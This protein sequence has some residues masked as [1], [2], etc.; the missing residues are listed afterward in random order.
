MRLP[1]PG[2]PA[3]LLAALVAAACGSPEPTAERGEA[4]GKRPAAAKGAGPGAGADEAEA[5]KGAPDA[6]ARDAAAELV[7]RLAGS[8][9]VGARPISPRS[10]SVKVA[11]ASGDRAVFKPL[12]KTNRTARYEVAFHRIA[13]LVGA[14]RVPASALRRVPLAQIAGLLEVSYP[15]SAKAL[16]EEAL[17]DGNGLVGGA[18]IEWI[19]ELGPP[20]FA[21]ETGRKALAALLAADGPAPAAEPGV[22]AAS[23]MVVADYV[24]GNWDRFSG[25]N[26]F[27]DA[28]GRGL[29]LVDNNGSF[30]RWSDKQRARMDGQL[31]ACGRF[32]ASQIERLRAL[33]AASIRA[34]LADEEA[35]GVVEHLLTDEEVGLVLERRDAVLGRVDAEIAGRGEAAV[36][37][38][39]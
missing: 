16:R 10:L 24:A 8:A 1:R 13:A 39:P 28:S 20:R 15:E 18:I 14:D 21:G 4:P 3:V 17:A 6:G 32:S 19:A 29:W 9:V 31:A 22:A 5:P 37:P 33:T 7:E 12:R 34:A 25:G 38:F 30:A 23:R 2:F 27:A 35:R 26:L 11:L 36:I